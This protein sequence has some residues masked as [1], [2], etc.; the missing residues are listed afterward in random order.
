M[1][2]CAMSNC[3][4]KVIDALRAGGEPEIRERLL[5]ATLLVEKFTG[6]GDYR[7]TSPAVDAAEVTPESIAELRMALIDFARSQRDIPILAPLFG[8]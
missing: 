7:G 3:V 6:S 8:H 5:E 1:P 2:P 4:S